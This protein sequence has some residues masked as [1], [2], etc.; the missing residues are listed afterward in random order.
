MMARNTAT[1]GSTGS[2]TMPITISAKMAMGRSK[3]DCASPPVTVPRTEPTSRKYSC[4]DDAGRDS[5]A[6]SGRDSIEFSNAPDT[7]WSREHRERGIPIMPAL[8]DR[9]ANVVHNI[10]VVRATADPMPIIIGVNSV[11]LATIA[12]Q[13]ADGV[14]I[15]LSS[16]HSARYL[17]A[18]REA[19]GDKPFDC[20]GWAPHDD[21]AS[22][23]KAYELGLD[24]LIM[25][26][27]HSL[28]G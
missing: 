23:D 18:A 9:H 21:K 26:R 10:E 17:A 27:L 12:G 8:A 25:S 2:A 6:R 1:T 15:R 5:S 22:Q 28:D 4:H 24:R 20:S 11:E 7:P 19:A 3:I 16:P 13:H 14:N